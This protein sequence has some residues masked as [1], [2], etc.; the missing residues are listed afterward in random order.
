MC[1]LPRGLSDHLGS[2]RLV[3]DTADGAVFERVDYA[4]AGTSR[5]GALKFGRCGLSWRRAVLASLV[6]TMVLAALLDAHDASALGP[7]DVEVAGVAGRRLSAI[8]ASR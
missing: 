3:V 2:P 1:A 7:V 4:S 5:G 8:R 6:V